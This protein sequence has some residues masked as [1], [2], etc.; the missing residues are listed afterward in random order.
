MKSLLCRLCPWLIALFGLAVLFLSFGLF[1][2][3]TGNILAWGFSGLPSLE[4]S[5]VGQFT[6]EFTHTTQAYLALLGGLLLAVAVTLVQFALNQVSP[7]QVSK[8]FIV[9]ILV[10]TASFVAFNAILFSFPESGYFT[11]Y[12]KMT[13]EYSGPVGEKYL[14]KSRY[15]WMGLPFIAA[16]ACLPFRQLRS[17]PALCFAIGIGLAAALAPWPIAHYFSYHY[18][19]YSSPEVFSPAL[20]ILTLPILLAPSLVAGLIT[21]LN[22]RKHHNLD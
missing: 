20:K 9:A 8:V 7:T 17:F 2:S 11:K 21:R 13:T 19:C 16:L 5:L 3:G 14:P 6:Y 18:L 10:G 12:L 15:W 22:A 1:T 4:S